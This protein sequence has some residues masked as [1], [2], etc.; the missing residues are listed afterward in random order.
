MA[1]NPWGFG[2]PST[3]EGM[4]TSDMFIK[5]EFTGNPK[6][7]RLNTWLPE[8]DNREFSLL[9]QSVQAPAL[10]AVTFRPG[11]NLIP[12]DD[13]YRKLVMNGNPQTDEEWE[14]LYFRKMICKK[15]KLWNV[16]ETRKF[17]KDDEHEITVFTKELFFG[18]PVSSICV[19]FIHENVVVEYAGKVPFLVPKER[20]IEMTLGARG[21]NHKRINARWK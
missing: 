10:E 21:A 12:A 17:I 9:N 15:Y 19:D 16:P 11:F 13:A 4:W 18:K 1:R 6:R 2:R 20:V 3:F 14:A 8:V 7:I 5:R